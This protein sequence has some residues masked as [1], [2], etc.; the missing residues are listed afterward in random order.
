VVVGVAADVKG[1]ADSADGDVPGV[2]YLPYVQNA[3]FLT[4]DVTFVVHARVP[5]E[6]LLR[7]VRAAIAATDPG[8]APYGF[9]T[10]ERKVGDTY[11]EDRFAL[12]LV[13]LFGV[14]GLVLSAI[15]LYG[16]LS[17]QVA[18]RTREMG[19]RA[20]LGAEGHDILG[21]VFREGASLLGAGL[22]AGLVLALAATRLLASQLHGV[23]PQDPIAHL[24][25]GGVLSLAAALAC[26]LP[27][28]RAAR[29]DPMVALRTD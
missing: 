17:F 20:A 16:L 15:G 26:W 5:A 24:V 10:L 3:G 29:V 9:T 19:V 1:I 12:L 6:S 25:A 4:D 2:W 23:G 22:A 14:L 27:A 7:P 21:L 8:L 28:R 11:V 18:R 13:G